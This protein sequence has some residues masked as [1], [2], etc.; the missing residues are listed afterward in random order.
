MKLI[1]ALNLKFLQ[2]L[3]FFNFTYYQMLKSINKNVNSY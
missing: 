1:F 3:A 2:Y